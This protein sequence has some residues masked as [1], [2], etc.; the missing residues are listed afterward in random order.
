ML[1]SIKNLRIYTIR[2][3]DGDI[4]KVHDFFFDDQSWT[5]RYL[6]ADT[7]S[8]LIGRRV[9]IS[10]AALGQPNWEARILPVGLTKKQVEDSPPISTDKPVSRQME[11]EL[12]KHYGWLPYTW[13]VR[14]P[15]MAQARVVETWAATEAE[16]EQ[17]STKESKDDPHLRSTNEVIG[18]HIQFPDAESGHMEDLRVDDESWVIRYIELKVQDWLPD[19][20]ALVSPQWIKSINWAERR[21]N[22]Y[23][24][25]ETIKRAAGVI[26]A[27]PMNRE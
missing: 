16:T 7:G 14:A 12:R 3:T 19:Q 15:E 24:L 26:P 4:G 6:V 17:V 1:R 10:P 8:W 11:R 21:V 18:Y 5:I 9:L 27:V 22:V 23:P 2:A 25:K 20:I 13:R